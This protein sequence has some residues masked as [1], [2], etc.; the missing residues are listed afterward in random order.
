MSDG[1]LLGTWESGSH[2]Q[3]LGRLQFPQLAYNLWED[4]LIE[5]VNNT[6][7]EDLAK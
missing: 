5:N 6:K 1:S 7:T 3:E 2:T 4:L